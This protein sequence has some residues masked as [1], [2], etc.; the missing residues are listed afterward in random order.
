LD[1]EALEWSSVYEDGELEGRILDRLGEAWEAEDEEERRR[2][3][4]S[5]RT[6]KLPRTPNAPRPTPVLRKDA[7]RPP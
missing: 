4:V 6:R 1:E 3:R 2:A 7:R 5:E